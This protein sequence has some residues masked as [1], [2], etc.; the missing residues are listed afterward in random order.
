[1]GRKANSDKLLRH[2]LTCW[3]LSGKTSMSTVGFAVE[4]HN[5]EIRA[6]H[7]GLSSGYN[8][9]DDERSEGA[10]KKVRAECSPEVSPIGKAMS[11]L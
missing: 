4:P 1:M 8:F 7:T 6:A 9:L 11:T 3:R 5:A 10:A 2:L